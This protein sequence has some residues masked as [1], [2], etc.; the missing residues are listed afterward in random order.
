MIRFRESV[1]LVLRLF[2]VNLVTSQKFSNPKQLCAFCGVEPA[3][4]QSGTS[5][6]KGKMVKHGSSQLRYVLFKC[7]PLSSYS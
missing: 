1:R 4:Y 2:S 5:L 7:S 6:I 3:I